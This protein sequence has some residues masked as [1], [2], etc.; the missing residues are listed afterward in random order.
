MTM[1][2]DGSPGTLVVTG[3]DY[4]ATL[5]NDYCAFQG[6]RRTSVTAFTDIA[7]TANGIGIKG[8]PAEVVIDPE[9]AL[10]V[11]HGVE[12]KRQIVVPGSWV[13]ETEAAT[14]EGSTVTF[15]HRGRI[16]RITLRRAVTK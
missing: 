12:T 11:A 8:G 14:V 1:T 15:T 5:A 7:V 2:L 6:S 9:R 3:K 4:H 10:I 16:S 13:S